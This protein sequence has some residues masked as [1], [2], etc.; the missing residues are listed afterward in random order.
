MRFQ[1]GTSALRGLLA[2][3]WKRRKSVQ[4]F[5]LT[6]TPDVFENIF[7]KQVSTNSTATTR[8]GSVP[9]RVNSWNSETNLQDLHVILKV[10]D[11]EE[12]YDRFS[13]GPDHSITDV[14]DYVPLECPVDIRAEFDL[15]T[16]EE[17]VDAMSSNV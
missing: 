15:D 4:P 13:A 6:E 7:T 16:S 11:H 3:T 17:Y 10:L 12:E 2:A 5:T 1:S 14:D 8:V 9:A